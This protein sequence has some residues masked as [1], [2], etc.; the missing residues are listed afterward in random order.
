MAT[1]AAGF[2]GSHMSD[3][4]LR[5]GHEVIGVDNLY[6]VAKTNISHLSSNHNFEWT[7]HDITF[8]LYLECELIMNFAFPASSVHYQENPVQTIKTNVYGSVNLL[9]LA[10]KLNVPIFQT[11]TSEVYGEPEIGLQPEN[12]WGNVNPIGPR[13]FYNEGKRAADTL[14]FDYPRQ[15]GLPIK[16]ARIFNTYGPRMSMHDGARETLGNFQKAQ[17]SK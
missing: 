9:G 15:Y 3:Y 13:A 7:R 16:V 2:L 10:K 14:F 5:N 6:T 4:L 8:T 1:G 17:V 11:S 12:Y